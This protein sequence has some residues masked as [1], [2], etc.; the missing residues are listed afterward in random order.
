M[1]L[2]VVIRSIST[3]DS[4]FPHTGATRYTNAA[5]RIPALAISNPDA[6]ALVR[7]FES[8]KPVRLQLRSSSRDLP[9]VRSANVVGEIPGT[10]RA[11]EIVILGAHLDSWDPGVGAIDDGAGVAIMMGVAKLIRELDVKPRRTDPRG[12]VRQRGIRHFRVAG[13][14]RR[15]RGRSRTPRARIRSRFRRGPG[16][17]PS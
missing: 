9:P 4:R 14:S 12:A 3:S 6:D 10:D 15:E 11:G 17:A 5:P 1:P 13:L 8:G 2:A 7:Q 16:L